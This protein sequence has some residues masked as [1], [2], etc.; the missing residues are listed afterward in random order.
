MNLSGRHEPTQSIQ[1]CQCT[2]WLGTTLFTA[3]LSRVTWHA[4]GTGLAWIARSVPCGPWQCGPECIYIYWCLYLSVGVVP[5]STLQGW[6]NK[7]KATKYNSQEK[8]GVRCSKLER[9]K[10]KKKKKDNWE[11]RDVWLC[12]RLPYWPNDRHKGELRFADQEA[13]VPNGPSR[14]NSISASSAW[15][16]T[17]RMALGKWESS[18][19]FLL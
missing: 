1:H 8:S 9:T 4:H 17:A 18:C 15:R 5:E 16:S 12:S 14:P 19:I 2:T 6:R 7:K 11:N 10:K 13:V 3:P